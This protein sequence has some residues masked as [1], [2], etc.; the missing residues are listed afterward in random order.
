MRGIPKQPRVN[1]GTLLSLPSLAGIVSAARASELESLPRE[2]LWDLEEKYD[3]DIEAVYGEGR[4]AAELPL[5]A[6]AV[7]TW[8]HRSREACQVTRTTLRDAPELLGPIMKHPGP[9]FHQ[10]GVYDTQGSVGELDPA[11]YLEA[12]GDLPLLSFSGGVDFDRALAACQE[13]LA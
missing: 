4:Q 7:L 3:V 5:R 2:E 6:F 9:F 10:G 8:S 11:P 1:P 12:L 13:A